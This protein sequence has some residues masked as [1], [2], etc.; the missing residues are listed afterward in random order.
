M[1]DP[2]ER[3]NRVEDP[4]QQRRIR[5]LSGMLESWFAGQATVQHDGRH[6]PVAGGGQLRPVGDAREDGPSA[7]VAH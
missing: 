5:E 7:F 6:L 4:A 3:D 1:N 2:G